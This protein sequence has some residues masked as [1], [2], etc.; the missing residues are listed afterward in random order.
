MTQFANTAAR[1]EV[2]EALTISSGRKRRCVPGSFNIRNSTVAER[3]L[4]DRVRSESMK[5]VACC[6]LDRETAQTLSDE[7]HQTCPYFKATR[8]DI[9]VETDQV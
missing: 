1:R 4:D 5:S 8:G 3:A 2:L 6:T 7:A 9:D